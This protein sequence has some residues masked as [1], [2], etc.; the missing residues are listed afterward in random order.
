MLI[1]EYQ[2][3]ELI[4][5]LGVSL[6][7]GKMASSPDEAYKIAEELQAKVV[8]K[9]Q[10]HAGGRGKA[11]GVK[12]AGTPDEARAAAQSIL[13]MKI[14]GL[15]VEKVLV[16]K[17]VN[18][19]KEFY[20]GI[21]LDRSRGKNCFM[22]SPMGGV[23]IEDVAAKHPDKIFKEYIDPYLG[24]LSYQIRKMICPL[25]LTKE[26]NKELTGFMKKLYLAYEKYDCSLA[27]IN[28]LVATKEG[29]FIAADAKINL[30][31]NALFR[32]PELSAYKESA[33]DDEIEK[34][35]H[36]KNIAYVRLGG[37]IGI[38]GNG[39][40]LVMTTLDMVARE[41]GKPANFLDI[42]GGAN[43][44]TVK[45][46]LGIVL[47][48]KNVKGVLFNIFGGIVRCD[49]V[50]QGIKNA[51]EKMNIKVPMVI[52][53]C[54][55]REKEGKEILKDSNLTPAEN[56]QDGARKIVELVSK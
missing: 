52:R 54:G 11:G 22:F 35:A 25:C 1:H 48:D 23:D 24:L 30:D 19:D 50:A 9:A 45:Q 51:A 18:I 44:E 31:D 34:I 8:V 7:Q 21:T 4:G 14:K 28:P 6:P 20:I 56:M 36:E 29:A 41:G 39:A 13:G 40:G 37:N 38:L 46:A 12:L 5:K 47:M 26:Q 53:L 10:V 27:E 49:T 42:G 43:E 17:A 16:E 3:K 15:T 55:T 33:E 32:H 2:A